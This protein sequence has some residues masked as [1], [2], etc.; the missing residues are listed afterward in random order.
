MLAFSSGLSIDAGTPVAVSDGADVLRPFR[1][2]RRR[3]QVIDIVNE[4]VVS[5]FL[6]RRATRRTRGAS[7]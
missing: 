4:Q 6:K 2:R 5:C 1:V 7:C 3:Y